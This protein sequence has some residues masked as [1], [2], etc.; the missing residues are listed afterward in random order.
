VFVLGALWDV[1]AFDQWGVELGKQLAGP[2]GKALLAG[3]GAVTPVAGAHD[4]STL[5]LLAALRAAQAVTD[6][7]FK[8]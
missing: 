2:I 1:N 7:T 5:G 8:S 3:A 6:Q 4:G